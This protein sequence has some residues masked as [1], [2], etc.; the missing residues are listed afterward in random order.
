VIVH[1]FTADPRGVA[2]LVRIADACGLVTDTP[3]LRG[4]G[5]RYQDLRGTQWDHWLADVTAA[6]QRL[7]PHVAGIVLIGFS[8]GGL[9]ALASA[10]QQ[11]AGIVAL[12]A[13]APAVR[14]AHPLAPF[15]WLARD[16]L[17]YVPMGK[18]V[19]YSDAALAAADDSYPTLALDAFAS[20][21]TATRRVEA[22]LP[23]ITAPLLLIHA[24]RDRVIKPVSS[25]IVF[26][27]VRSSV[28]ELVWLERSG[29]AMLDDCD[30]A[31]V[32]TQV[33]RFLTT[34][35]DQQGMRGVPTP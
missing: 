17:P 2:P 9:L 29:H 23:R 35:V 4:H 18:S 28:K 5:G 31:T 24:R 1:G 30:A 11:P 8:M 27:N 19:A 22:L 20:F 14:I 32:S 3:L 12:V 13:L 25:Q 21:F 16:W 10:A 6:R 26:D 7:S 33:R 15:A 34:Q